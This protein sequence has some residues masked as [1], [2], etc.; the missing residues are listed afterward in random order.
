[1]SGSVTVACML[2]WNRMSTNVLKFGY[3]SLLWIKEDCHDSKLGGG[4]PW[5]KQYSLNQLVVHALTGR[6]VELIWVISLLRKTL[7]QFRMKTEF[8][9][10]DHMA[11]GLFPMMPLL[12]DYLPEDLGKLSS[13][14]LLDVACYEHLN[15]FL[16][17]VHMKSSIT[18]VTGLKEI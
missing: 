1:M 14:M 4:S 3:S 7:Y 17:R 2:R 13:I 15:I 16:K 12:L 5:H 10:K 9:F 6:W 18:K 8:L 11:S